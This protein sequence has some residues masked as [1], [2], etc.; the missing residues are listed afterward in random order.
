MSVF[1]YTVLFKKKKTPESREGRGRPGRGAFQGI[2]G[3]KPDADVQVA[4]WGSSG[5]GGY[6][7][8]CN[9]SS[10]TH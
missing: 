1:P 8:Q 6:W 2:C 4:E 10:D 3:N 7:G 9:R 5:P